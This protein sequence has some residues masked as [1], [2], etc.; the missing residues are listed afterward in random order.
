LTRE[1]EEHGR[2]AVDRAVPTLPAERIVTLDVIRG[3]A[4]LGILVVNMASFSGTA[5]DQPSALWDQAAFFFVDVFFSGKFNSLFSML[6][7]IGFTIQ[8]ER[9]EQRAGNDA[10]WIYVRR[11]LVTIT[12]CS[13]S[14]SCSC[15]TCRTAP[16]SRSLRS[17]CSGPALA[18]LRCCCSRARSGPRPASRIGK[19]SSR[20][21]P[22]RSA[23]AAM[24]TPSGT[25]WKRCAAPI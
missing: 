6:F 24:P 7:A 23:R 9:L 22:R 17:C 2:L 3:F 5:L 21:P 12:R 8:L 16:C 13:A 11:M 18:A 25:I 14:C 10:R 15:A 19:S 1:V 20:P 4:L